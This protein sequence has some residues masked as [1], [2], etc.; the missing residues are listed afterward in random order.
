MDA[1]LKNR[2]RRVLVPPFRLIVPDG[3][4][5][6]IVATGSTPEEVL[7]GVAALRCEFA[8]VDGLGR[9][10]LHVRGPKGDEE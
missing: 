5:D 4:I 6:F 3:A 10:V 9:P 2:A 8:V 7:G 1:M